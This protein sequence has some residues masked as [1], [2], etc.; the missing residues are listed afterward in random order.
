M[1]RR[2]K[3]R[4][5]KLRLG[6]LV[7]VRTG[8]LGTTAV[9]TEEFAGSN[10][11]DLVISRPKQQAVMPEY[12]ANWINSDEGKNQILQMQGGLAQQHFNVGDMKTLKVAIPAV[13]EQRK[14][15]NV[16]S[17]VSKKLD[18]LTTQKSQTQQLKKG[19]MQKLLT[20]QIR[21]KPEPQDH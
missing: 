2:L 21:V 11:V 8:Y 7:T 17:S 1:L 20:G 10:C 5:S 6:D 13:Y 15:V 19:L 14:I 16:I 18:H 9:V 3:W 12:L 4:K